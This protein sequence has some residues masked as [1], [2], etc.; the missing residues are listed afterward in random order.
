MKFNYRSDVNAGR[1]R[2]KLTGEVNDKTGKV[3]RQVYA[4]IVKRTPVLKGD[5]RASWNVSIDAPD[6]TLTTGGSKENPLP[7]KPFP[8]VRITSLSVWYISN[9]QPYARKM[10]NGGSS[11]A[12]AGMVRVTIASIK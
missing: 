3:V 10:E 9:G 12:P 11:K 5:L 4:G 6:Y 2:A 7:P 8:N 1:I